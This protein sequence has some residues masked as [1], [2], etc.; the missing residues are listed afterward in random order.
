MPENILDVSADILRAHFE[1]S[2]GNSA[3]L[4]FCR[5]YQR[6]LPT[7]HSVVTLKTGLL[8]VKKASSY[9]YSFIILH[10]LR[11]I[12]TKVNVINQYTTFDVLYRTG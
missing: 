6:K 5:L 7:I 12:C 1:S 4:L 10:K 2:L 9:L 11:F 3:S 8:L